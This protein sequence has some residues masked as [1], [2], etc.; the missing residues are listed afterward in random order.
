MG[1][2]AGCILY[3]IRGMWMSPK[4]ERLYG[5]IMLLKKRAPILGG[6]IQIICRQF[7]SL[8]RFVFNIQLRTDLHQ[9]QVRH[10]KP[11]HRRWCYWWFARI[12]SRSQNCL[13][14]RHFRSPVLGGHRSCGDGHDQISTKTAALNAKRNVRKIDEDEKKIV[15]ENASRY[16]QSDRRGHRKQQECYRD[17]NHFDLY[18][19]ISVNILQF[20]ICIKSYSIQYFRLYL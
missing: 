3:L 19:F 10:D 13:Q 16:V 15:R 11:N 5:G 18:F 20:V 9:E 4:S 17:V 12:Q 6:K 7:R 14:E 1:C 8:G 2:A